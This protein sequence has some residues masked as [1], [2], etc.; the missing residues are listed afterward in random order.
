[1]PQTSKGKSS[2]FHG[3]KDLK[4]ALKTK[5][6]HQMVKFMNFIG[7]VRNRELKKFMLL[8]NKSRSQVLL[9]MF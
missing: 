4:R 7:N 3:A 5:T 8:A 2:N 9:K 6:V 1:M